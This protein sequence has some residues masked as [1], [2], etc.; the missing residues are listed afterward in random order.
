[1]TRQPSKKLLRP[2]VTLLLGFAIIP[3]MAVP[4]M[5]GQDVYKTL[6]Q[7]D[8]SVPEKWSLSMGSDTMSFHR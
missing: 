6:K 3:V 8:G 7:R 4:G 2:F 5:A 1:M